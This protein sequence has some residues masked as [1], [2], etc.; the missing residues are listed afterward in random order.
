[1]PQT[2]PY[3]PLLLRLLHSINAILI[4]GALITGFL[5]YD[6]WDGRFGSLGIT[7][8]N[9]DL[10]DIHGTFGFFISFVALP[11]F[12]IYCWNAGRQRLIQASTFKQL[13]NVRKPAWWYALQQ[14]INTLVLLAALF[15]VISGKFQDENWLPQ[16][17][18]NHIAY[19]IHLI[20]WVVIV[21]ALLMHLLMS[22]KVGG[23]PLLLSMLDITYRP[24]DSPRLWRQKIVN[25]FQK[26]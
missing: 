21:I 18:L 22:A 13:G 12:L 6:S 19:Y 26:K 7:R 14:V 11:I 20:A 9:R 25:W 17:E 16:G 3:Q 10:I 23:F 1:M 5:V 24:N 4:I 15:S 8:V 2:K